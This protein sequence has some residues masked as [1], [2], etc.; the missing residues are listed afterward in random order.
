MAIGKKIVFLTMFV[1]AAAFSA[2]ALAQESPL[3]LAV[4][5]F[6]NSSERARYD[7]LER[8][9]AEMLKTELSQCRQIAVLERKKIESILSEY[10]LAQAGYIK[11]EHALEVGK[12]AGAEYI[13]TGEIQR[14]SGDLR[15]DAHLIRVS[16]GQILGE[17]VTGSGEEN[18]QPMVRM[19]AQNIIFDLTGR[20]SRAS[21][22]KIRNYNTAY[23]AGVTGALALTTILVHADYRKNYD[24]YHHATNFDDFDRYYDR[25]NRSHKIR[26]WLIAATATSMIITITLWSADRSRNNRVFAANSRSKEH[27][28]ANRIN[29]ALLPGERNFSLN[30]YVRF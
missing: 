8:A 24:N 6:K 3:T 21:E 12:L 27:K 25:A 14:V 15:I 10:A 9:V 19:L 2:K 7:R 4:M 29:L 20:G 18:L 5:D 22:W 17:K 13:I 1:V 23:A 16:T 26:N 28:F 30:L 11:P